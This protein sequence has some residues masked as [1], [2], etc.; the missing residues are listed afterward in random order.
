ME[1]RDF[2]PR[3]FLK[4]NITKG[5]E[6]GGMA[7]LRSRS[8]DNMIEKK[9][10]LLISAEGEKGLMVLFPE[11]VRDLIV[12]DSGIILGTDYSIM[13]FD[14]KPQSK[15]VLE[16]ICSWYDLMDVMKQEDNGTEN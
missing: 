15:K 11:D 1:K 4:F 7:C 16:I 9:Q 5:I 3:L 2:N 10:P 6:Y 14:W 12:S 8:I 13:R